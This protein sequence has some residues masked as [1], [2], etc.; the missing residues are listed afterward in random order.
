MLISPRMHANENDKIEVLDVSDSRK[1]NNIPERKRVI[2]Q[3]TGSAQ[4][5]GKNGVRWRRTNGKM[6]RS[7]S[8]VRISDDC[9]KV[10]QDKKEIFFTALMVSVI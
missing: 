7:G 2:A 1:L 6:I 9:K 5:V 4:P 3:F 8:F 10:S